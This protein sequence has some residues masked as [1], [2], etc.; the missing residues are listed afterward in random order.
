MHIIL[1]TIIDM[2]HL[3]DHEPVSE[4][5][6]SFVMVPE[7]PVPESDTGNQVYHN[8]F[9]LLDLGIQYLR[10]CSNT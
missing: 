2:T 6:E 4:L 1:Y 7:H 10:M 9:T 8:W 3:I 5:I